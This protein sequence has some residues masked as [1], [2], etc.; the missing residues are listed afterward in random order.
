[1]LQAQRH[2]IGFVASDRCP[3][4]FGRKY[5]KTLIELHSYCRPATKRVGFTR[6]SNL[7]P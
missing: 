3:T 4:L 2:D 7:S 5:E 1:M 6:C